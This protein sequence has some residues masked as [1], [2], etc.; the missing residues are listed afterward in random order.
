MKGF[1]QFFSEATK[2]KWFSDFQ[3]ETVE[4]AH[5]DLM[6]KSKFAELFP[7]VKGVSY[8]SFQKIVGKHPVTGQIIPITRK[9]DF[10]C[11]PSLHKCDARCRNAKGKNC[12]CSCRGKNHGAGFN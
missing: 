9:I 11:N 3:G 2:A 12:E 10:K 6:T 7:N 8:D 1:K 4:V 5:Y